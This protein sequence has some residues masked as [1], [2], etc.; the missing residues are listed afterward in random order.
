M[1]LIKTNE[2]IKLM[3]LAGERLAYVFNAIN[4]SEWIG[5]TKKQL[6]LHVAFLLDKY[7]M[8]SCCLGYKQ[9]SGYSCISLNQELVH[10]VPNETI[11]TE[12]DFLKLDICASYK[13]FCADAARIFYKKGV[14]FIFDT[15][16][17]CANESLISGINAFQRGNTV[18]C[19]GNAIFEVIKNYRYAVVEDFAGHG[20][21]KQM[22]EPPEVLN[23]GVKKRGQQFYVGMAL[24]IEPMFCQ[25]SAALEHDKNDKWTVR[26]IDKG[27][28]A[29]I[30]DT[31]VLTH[32][33]PVITTR[34]KKEII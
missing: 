3:L 14:N 26:T 4:F 18:G 21:G 1:K 24:A 23:Y 33:G 7:E 29:H 30:E 31:V 10:G 15:M 16:E 5:K 17:K 19:I 32:E 6:D 8:K 11:I 2:E 34:L 13:G 20:I 28:A 27:L 22:H 12:V 9:F 25:F